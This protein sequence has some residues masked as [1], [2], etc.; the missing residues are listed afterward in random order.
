MCMLLL[1]V[2]SSA[3][4]V[5]SLL[6]VDW[7]ELVV[8][9]LCALCT[10]TKCTAYIKQFVGW[11]WRVLRCSEIVLPRTFQCTSNSVNGSKG[12]GMG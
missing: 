10:A 2:P 7:G 9:D 8:H 5:L 6:K 11:H 4:P 12:L 3:L 1:A